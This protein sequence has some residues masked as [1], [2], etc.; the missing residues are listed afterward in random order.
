MQQ[1][2]KMRRGDGKLRE[3]SVSTRIGH[4]QEGFGAQCTYGNQEYGDDKLETD[5]TGPV[6]SEGKESLR[7]DRESSFLCLMRPNAST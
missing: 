1:A 3:K 4:T 6:P 5:P 7:E 2:R